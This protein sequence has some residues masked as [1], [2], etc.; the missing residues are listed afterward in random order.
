MAQDGAP[1]SQEEIDALIARVAR[2]RADAEAASEPPPS[3]TER[4]DAQRERLGT[5]DAV[6]EG[7]DAAALKAALEFLAEEIPP[8]LRD[9]QLTLSIEM[10]RRAFTVGEVLTWTAGKVV[11]FDTHYSE[12]V[13]L[14]VDDVALATGR[15][16]LLA[17]GRLGVLVESVLA[18]GRPG[19]SWGDPVA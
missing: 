12:T 3:A 7:V 11:T 19:P 4:G 1:L 8:R 17:D 6:R 16:V 10:G 13:R 18:P 9:L 5:T 14:I 2:E 15:V